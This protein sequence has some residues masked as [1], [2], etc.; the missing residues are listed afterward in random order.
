[1]PEELLRKYRPVGPP[2]DLRTRILV[3]ERAAW[4]WATAAAVLLAVTFGFQI[5]TSRLDIPQE[6]TG[7]EPF[8]DDAR[9]AYATE[10]LG[11]GEENRRIATLI[12]F[13]ERMRQSLPAVAAAPRM[14]EGVQ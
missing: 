10:V 13:E 3:P 1:L 14:P 2:P 11:G 5:A 7:K 12:V 8:D 9:I 4:P 6:T